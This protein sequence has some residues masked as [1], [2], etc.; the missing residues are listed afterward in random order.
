MIDENKNYIFISYSHKDMNIIKLYFEA[1]NQNFNIWFDEG[2]EHSE[3]TWVRQIRKKI[4]NSSLFLAF[5]TDDYLLSKNCIR[6]LDEAL[7]QQKIVVPIVLNVDKETDDFKDFNFKC[8]TYQILYIK[9]DD[10]IECFIRK[11]ENSII[12]NNIDLIY[13]T[14]EK[15]VERQKY[16]KKD[17]E[18]FFGSYPNSLVRI[19]DLIEELNSKVNIPTENNFNGWIKDECSPNSLESI[20]YIDITYKNQKYRGVLFNSYW[21]AHY[22]NEIG[23]EYGFDH[24]KIY[25]FKYEPIE[26]IIS[27]DYEGYYYL[28]TKNMIDAR[29]GY[30]DNHNKQ[31]YYSS[32]LRDF[33]NNVFLKTAFTDD[34]IKIIHNKCNE[35]FFGYEESKDIVT[36]PTI[37]IIANINNYPTF[38]WK[39]PDAIMKTDYAKIRG[40]HNNEY[41]ILYFTENRTYKDVLFCTTTLGYNLSYGVI[42][43]ICIKK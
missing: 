41:F 36:I 29:Y 19:Y 9:D 30:L 25:W 21:W 27:Y 2:I 12:K 16:I 3:E 8:R 37:E 4:E 42:P 22:L 38:E 15:S 10:T 26:W 28:R 6:E 17:S 18:I 31:I 34:D 40:V 1:L 32:Y 24:D 20:F 14:N 43:M 23:S 11:I 13:K 5:I 33:L 7:E 39:S 35:M